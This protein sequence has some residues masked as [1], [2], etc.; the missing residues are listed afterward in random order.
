MAQALQA[1]AIRDDARRESHVEYDALK[2]AGYE[3]TQS[4]QRGAIHGEYADDQSQ[5]LVEQRG[6]SR[7]R[8]QLRRRPIARR[9]RAAAVT[10]SV[11][12]RNLSA[13]WAGLDEMA[14]RERSSI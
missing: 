5:Q 11:T 1:R 7:R 3:S 8:Q 12:I 6:L 13:Y 4:R 14:L 2:H 9:R 10:A